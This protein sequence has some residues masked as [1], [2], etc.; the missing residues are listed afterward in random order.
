[1]NTPA[2][3]RKANRLIGLVGPAGAGKDTVREIL[4][5]S[6]DYTGLAFADP[7]RAM[8][9]PLI[10]RFVDGT[11]PVKT[12]HWYMTDRLGKETEIPGMGASYRH[13][14]QTLG[15]EWAR[16]CMGADFWTRCAEASVQR[17]IKRC[18]VTRLVFSDV[19]FQSEVDWIRQ[20]GGTLWRI[21]RPQA[22][23]VREH[24]SESAGKLLECDLTIDN[25]G[26]ID[27]LWSRVYDAVM[28]SQS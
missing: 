16:Q 1:M 5:Q 6:H 13:L 2:S 9:R 26:S 17:E 8:L 25:S 14:A 11:D 27:E 10:E 24:V 22:V 20:R 23:P 3:H 7:L 19:R 21:E 15:T 28:G 18:G 12:A 4:V